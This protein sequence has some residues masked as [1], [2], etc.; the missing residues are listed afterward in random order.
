M[1]QKV[2]YTKRECTDEKKIAA[3]L[4]ETRVGIL[5][6]ADDGMPYAVPV[7][8]VWY[9][10]A[11]YFH[12]MGSGRKVRLLARS[13]SVCFTVYR[14]NGTV[15]DPVPCQADTSY[16]SV[17]IFGKAEQV[18]D[19]A[20]AAE[21]LQFFL[22]KYAPGYYRQK[23]TGGLIDKYRSAMDGKRV[24]V[25]RIVPDEMTAKENASEPDASFHHSAS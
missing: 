19:F 5:G 13:P 11:I 22:G 6:L 1:T 8:F 4:S 14:E 25:Y 3:L 16:L 12:G 7:N 2:S 23:I 20:A 24:A 21:A 15:S 18:S 10:G 9:E 17:M